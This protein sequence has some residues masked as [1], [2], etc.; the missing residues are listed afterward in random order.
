MSLAVI[1]PQGFFIEL[2]FYKMLLKTSD[3]DFNLPEELIAHKPANPR[4]SSKMLIWK[5][6]KITDK[7]VSDLADFLEAG[8]LLVLN[9]TKVI[10]AKLIGKRGEAK[11]EINLHKNVKDG[12]WQV[13]AKGLRKLKIGD[14]FIIANDFYAKVLAKNEAKIVEMEFNK[15]GQDFFDA[16]EKY[17]QMPLPPYIKQSSDQNVENDEI[18]DKEQREEGNN[19]YQTVYAKNYGAV[20]APTAGLHF[21]E[22]LF[23]KLESRGIK[24]TFTTLNV[25]AGTFLPVK[26]DLIKDHKMHSEFFSISKETCDAINEAKNNGKRIV[27]IGTTSLRVLESAC[28]E[29][30]FLS[31]QTRETDIFIYPPYKFKVVDI[32]MTNYH[33]PKSTLFMLISAFVGISEVRKIY[34]HAI[35]SDYR[36]YS[37]GDSSLLFGKKRI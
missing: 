17:G 20:A 26:A 34:N 27:A 9:D 18:E 19:S 14:Q 29:D 8:D 28:N 32:L 25:G 22:E 21:T 7:K 11:I 4:D 37:F 1:H 13:F 12:I 5:D 3:F 6:E 36:F 2:Y 23:N 30:G 16:L 35:E 33:L 15:S 31:P 24:T 10:K